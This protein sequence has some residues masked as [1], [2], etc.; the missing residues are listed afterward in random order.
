MKKVD[1]SQILFGFIDNVEGW[2]V[3]LLISWEEAVALI[4]AYDPANQYSPDAATSREIARVF[5]DAL[6]KAMEE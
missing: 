1:E 5:L 2:S 4:Q 6:K 3:P